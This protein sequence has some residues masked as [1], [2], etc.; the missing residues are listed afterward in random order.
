MIRRSTAPIFDVHRA[1]LGRAAFF[2]ASAHKRPFKRLQIRMKDNQ[3]VHHVRI[4]QAQAFA[5]FDGLRLSMAWRSDV[6]AANAG[7]ADDV[8][9]W[10]TREFLAKIDRFGPE[11]VF[12]TWLSRKVEICNAPEVPLEGA[13]VPPDEAVHYARDDDAEDLRIGDEWGDLGLF[14]YAA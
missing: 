1:W 8:A 11:A 14:D 3:F 9:G 7:L 5:G 12:G 4:A 13:V 10:S 2:H 6:E